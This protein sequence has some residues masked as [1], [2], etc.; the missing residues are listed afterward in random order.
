MQEDYKA[1]QVAYRLLLENSEA[2]RT[3]SARSPGTAPLNDQLLTLNEALSELIAEVAFLLERG[4]LNAAAFAEQVGKIHGPLSEAHRAYSALRP[5][6]EN[7]TSASP[8][9]KMLS[10]RSFATAWAAWALLPCLASQAGIEP[11]PTWVIG[12]VGRG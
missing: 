10:P 7:D 11:A 9:R 1:L 2:I 12:P 8:G 5:P 6:T 4:G 3:I